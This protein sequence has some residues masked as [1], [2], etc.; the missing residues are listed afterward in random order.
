[1]HFEANTRIDLV[2]FVD[3]Q[4]RE[5]QFWMKRDDLIDPMVSG[6]KLYKLKWNAAKALEENRSIVTF[7]GAFSNHLA[8]TALFCQNEGIPCTGIVRGEAPKPLNPTLAFCEKSG[9]ELQ[10]VSR[11]E[12]RSFRSDLSEVI[13]HWPNSLIIAEGGANALGA[14]GASEIYTRECEGF[15]VIALAI[16]T[17]TTFAGLAN[18]IHAKQQLIGFPVLKNE[19]ILDEIMPFIH[20]VSRQKSFEINADFHFGG[21]AKWNN[22][23]IEFMRSFHRQTG[24]KLD[25]IYT[26]KLIFGIT[27]LL[28][29]DAYKNKKLLCIHTGGLQGIAGFEQ[30]FGF[31]IFV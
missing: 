11:S 12:Y 26:G 14:K 4:G 24:I 16:G 5:L 31:Q 20:P 1:M 28:V 7:G 10:F 6:N 30:R 3:Q 9:M 13:K 15:D 19:N 29:I 22:D 8:A 23:L 21:Y 27:K 17:G 25:P 2:N 18:S